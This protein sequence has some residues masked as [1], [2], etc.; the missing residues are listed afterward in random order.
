MN[1][2]LRSLCRTLA[3]AAFVLVSLCA[4]AAETK[5]N[6]VF[7]IVDD[8]RWDALGIT[9]HPFSKTPNIDRI[10]KE[11]AIFNNFFVT[12]PLCS[13]SRASFLTGQYVQTH[14][15]KGNTDSSALSHQLMTFPRLLKNHGYTAA[16]VGKWH[17]GGD[18]SPRPGFD[19]WLC[20]PGQGNY[21][22]PAVN[23]NGVKTNIMGYATD[24][25]SEH[26]ANFIRQEHKKPFVVYLSHKAVHG[27]F[28][29]AE[30][31]K[32]L[33]ADAK[34]PAPPNINDS[35][36]GKPA[37]TRAGADAAQP[38]ARKKREKPKKLQMTTG[39]V[40]EKTALAQLRCLASI[41]DGVGLV[42]K[43]LEETKKLDNTMVI[44]TS[45]NGYFWG[46]HGLGDKRWAYEES[47]RDP[48]LIRYPKLVKPGS[49]IDQLVLNIDI[50]PTLLEL[51][52]APIPQAV[53]GRSILPL[54]KQEKVDWRKSIFGEY[55]FEKGFPRTP[56]WKAIR[57]A[58]WKLIHYPELEGMDEL[59]N[60]KKDPFEMKNVIHESS[61]K[62]KLAEL[63]AGLKSF[64]K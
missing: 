56:T 11:G 29:P 53:E 7:I 48:L 35:L 45:D 24:I 40:S 47:I 42:L 54:F 13:P 55:Y 4:H 21:D 1:K 15:V 43:A 8:L 14:G 59:Y 2:H 63:R 39:A 34:L 22:N 41:D 31:H 62:T 16:Y 49:R 33:Y 64:L 52:G 26:A 44:F 9:G 20:P 10:G 51:G 19:Y 27:P 5:P 58:E 23:L 57:T 32:S 12:T 28:I 25:F 18:S 37:L 46:E 3:L 60:L 36:Q 6:I 38:D 50:A 30:R 61:A 17:M